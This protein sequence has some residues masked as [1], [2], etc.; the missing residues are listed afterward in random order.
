MLT[1]LKSER[2][3]DYLRW[4]AAFATAALTYG[5]A[6]WMVLRPVGW[7]LDVDGPV[8]EINLRDMLQPPAIPPSDHA[9][10]PTIGANPTGDN[11][12]KAPSDSADAAPR[13]TGASASRVDPGDLARNADAK[14]GSADAPKTAAFEDR[15]SVV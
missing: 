15:K 8:V 12:Q 13:V 3:I 14:N 9:S 11:A 4:I 2:T 10:E 6:A 1:F 5:V 7:Q